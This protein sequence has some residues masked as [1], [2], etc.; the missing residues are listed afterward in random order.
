MGDVER[1]SSANTGSNRVLFV[2]FCAHL[3]GSEYVLATGGLGHVT[4]WNARLEPQKAIYC[5][6]A[7]SPMLCGAILSD[8]LVCGSFTGKIYKFHPGTRQCVRV[9]DAH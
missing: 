2:Q 8:H 6:N 1:R 5:K 3:R 7:I 4:F 9:A